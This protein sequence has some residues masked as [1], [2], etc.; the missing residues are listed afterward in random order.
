[1]ATELLELL[2]GVSFV[3]QRELRDPKQIAHLGL[4]PF[5]ARALSFFARY[6]DR[7]PNDFATGVERDKAQ[8][9]RVLKELEARGLIKRTPDPRDGRAVRIH[10]TE[11]G[12]RCHLA[13]EE[14][15]ANV[16]A[17]VSHTISHDELDTLQT[18][19]KKIQ[20]GMVNSAA[21]P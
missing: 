14:H 7:S 11:A 15:R 2:S 8:V 1:M 6:P 13:L 21:H 3:V 4:A 19:L 10:L 9:T 16:A 5:Q 20:D 17:A 18:I 12:R